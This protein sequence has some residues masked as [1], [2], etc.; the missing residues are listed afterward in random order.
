MPGTRSPVT[1]TGAITLPTRQ[2]ERVLLVS[3]NRDDPVAFNFD[4]KTAGGLT[5]R[6]DSVHRVVIGHFLLLYE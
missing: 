3:T 5:K 4:N 1:S 6:T 2:G